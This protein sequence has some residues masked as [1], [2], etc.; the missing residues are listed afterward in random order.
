MW[1]SLSSIWDSSQRFAFPSAPT[2]PKPCED[3]TLNW[4]ECIGPAHLHIYPGASW[5]LLRQEQILV[6]SAKAYLMEAPPWPQPHAVFPV[7]EHVTTTISPRVPC[8]S[9]LTVQ[10]D[11]CIF[12]SDILQ[13]EEISRLFA[14]TLKTARVP[15]QAIRADKRQLLS[16]SPRRFVRESFR[17]GLLQYDSWLAD[18]LDLWP[19]WLLFDSRGVGRK[20]DRTFNEFFSRS[21][22]PL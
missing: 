17:Y 12:R 19:S 4:F 16:W 22:T 15:I 11:L 10:F 13:I 9:N 7:T 3:L 21:S 6:N 8:T 1:R 14:K 18:S 20:Y 5:N 2:F